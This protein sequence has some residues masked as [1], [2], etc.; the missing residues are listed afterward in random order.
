LVEHDARFD[1]DLAID[2]G[3]DPSEVPTHVDNDG[4]AHGLSTL[5]GASAAWE[6]RSAGLARDPQDSLDV[7]GRLREDHP[8]RLDL[9]V[10]CIGRVEAPGERVE[11]D[12]AAKRITEFARESRIAG[13]D[14]AFWHA[15]SYVVP[16]WVAS[17]LP[18]IT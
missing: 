10:G 13:D 11:T 14:L 9:V 15:A 12:L 17:P 3:A 6:D 18:F 16:L 1:L 8:Q 2:D 4:S 5:R 7:L